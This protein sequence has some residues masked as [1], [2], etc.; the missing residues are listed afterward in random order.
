MAEYDQNPDYYLPPR[1]R[2]PT[3]APAELR[4]GEISEPSWLQKY[5]NYFSPGGLLQEGAYAAGLAETP[6]AFENW[7]KAG[8]GLDLAT[9]YM[10]LGLGLPR[11]LPLPHLIP[12]SLAAFPSMPHVRPQRR[13]RR[14]LAA[15]MITGTL[16][17]GLHATKARS[18]P[19]DHRTQLRTE[20]LARG[21]VMGRCPELWVA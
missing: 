15:P 10:V 17:A 8:N 2:M 21:C 5:G 16:L 18:T 4:A 1:P 9:F 13:V 6:Q 11:G 19:P 7:H 12:T 3:Y 14:L 20:S